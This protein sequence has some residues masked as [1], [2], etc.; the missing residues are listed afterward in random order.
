MSMRSWIRRGRMRGVAARSRLLGIS[1]DPAL[2]AKPAKEVVA[3]PANPARVSG[4]VALM[5]QGPSRHWSKP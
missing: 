1:P 3:L 4:S 5:T 2:P